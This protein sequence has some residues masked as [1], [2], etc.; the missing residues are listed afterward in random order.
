M[1]NTRAHAYSTRHKHKATIHDVNYIIYA[2]KKPRASDVFGKTRKYKIHHFLN[3]TWQNNIPYAR[4]IAAGKEQL[5]DFICLYKLSRVRSSLYEQC[6]SLEPVAFAALNLQWETLDRRV[7]GRLS[8]GRMYC[9]LVLI[10]A[11]DSGERP[12]KVVK[13]REFPRRWKWYTLS[14]RLSVRRAD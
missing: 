6:E 13:V 4:V 9:A 3:F 8:F 5:L 11:A 1:F 10:R 14:R 7:L 12:G 2:E